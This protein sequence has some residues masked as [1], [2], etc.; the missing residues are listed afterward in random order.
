MMYVEI[1]L[2]NQV[3]NFGYAA[4]QAKFR[5]TLVTKRISTHE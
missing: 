3:Q 5:R 4:K 1:N 2:K